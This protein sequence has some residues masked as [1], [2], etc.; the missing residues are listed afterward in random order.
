[1]HLLLL[2]HHA[3]IFGGRVVSIPATRLFIEKRAQP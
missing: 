3:S 2:F 1:V